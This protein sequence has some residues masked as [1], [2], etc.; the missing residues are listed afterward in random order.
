MAKLAIHTLI[1]VLLASAIP[2][3]APAQ[4]FTANCLNDLR[5]RGFGGYDISNVQRRDGTIRGIM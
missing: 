3:S 5:N 4:D 2:L 1:P